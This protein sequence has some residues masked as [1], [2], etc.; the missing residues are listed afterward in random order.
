MERT[1]PHSARTPVADSPTESEAVHTGGDVFIVDNSDERW[2]VR[3]YLAEWSDLARQLDI[4]TG[5]F[6]IGALLALEDHWPKLDRIRILLGAEVSAATK[7]ALLAGIRTQAARHLDSSLE[8]EKEDNDF[9][10][11]VPAIVEA[12]RTGKIECRVYSERKF[13]AKAYITHGRKAVLGSTALVGSSNFTRPGLTQNVELNIQVQRE[14]ADLQD[15]Y[16]RHWDEAD[17]VS[18]DV[19]RVIERHTREYPPFLVYA[20]ALDEFFRGH[21][22]TVG[23]WEKTQSQMYPV[24]DEYQREGY[25]ALV[26]IGQQ[27]GGALLCDGVG[28][29]KTFVGLMLIE[30]LV[31]HERKR[32]A[33]LSRRQEGSQ[34]G[35]QPCV[36]ICRA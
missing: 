15:W 12:L 5:Y 25:Q 28:L 11:G 8:Q 1:K 31:V 32:V 36:D 26:K 7:A 22:L 3:R 10:V 13:H 14:V 16:E 35:K 20:K 2:N 19:L 23:E 6:D 17:D 21:E 18:E 27:F 33:R 30:R 24:L 29:G 9:L 4:A 34:F